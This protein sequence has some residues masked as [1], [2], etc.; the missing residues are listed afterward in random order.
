MT[1]RQGLRACGACAGVGALVGLLVALLLLL[2]SARP[3]LW[4]A[5]G[6][7]AACPPWELAWALVR[8]SPAGSQIL[9]VGIAIVV[10]NAAIYAPFGLVLARTVA[11]KTAAKW[12][13]RFGGGVALLVIGHLIFI[14]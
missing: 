8:P 7:I 5:G 3:P 10:A 2:P 4:L 13:A 12:S 11:W 14:D 9:C 6:M 1:L